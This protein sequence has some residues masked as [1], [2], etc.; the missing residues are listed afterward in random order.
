M[1][2][3]LKNLYNKELV[4]QLGSEPA[5]LCDKFDSDKFANHVF[6]DE[7]KNRC[8]HQSKP[9]VICRR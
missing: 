7:W 6:D 2:E 4:S 1:P 5:R 3:P 8:K 9:A